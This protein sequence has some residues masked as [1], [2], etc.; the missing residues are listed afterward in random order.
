MR[1]DSALPSDSDH[2]GNIYFSLLKS[3]WDGALSLVFPASCVVCG[4]RVDS[5][6]F[7]PPCLSLLPCPVNPCER[8]GCPEIGT[9]SCPNCGDKDYVF[10]RL[11]VPWVFEDPVQ[12]LLHGLKYEGRT[13]VAPIIAA[14]MARRVR[15][16]GV[17]TPETV[18]VPV[19][20][21]PSR[22][23]E[24][25]YNQSYLLASAMARELGLLTR[26]VLRRT[27]ATAT[28]TALGQDE[29]VTNVAGAFEVKRPDAIRDR[30]VLL[31][32]DVCTTGSTLNAC[33]G[34]L[35]LA[36]AARVVAVA[37]AS[38]YRVE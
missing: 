5:S 25:G 22:L 26:D 33:T 13:F 20:L 1:H 32:D 37:A 21:H 28:Q 19:P 14:A 35:L 10:D 12:H 16:T 36:G 24:R 7:C 11:I 15:D 8:C 38:P 9:D 31:I 27:R 30:C 18:V 2:V 4:E 29:R 23:R 34:A 6:G 17:R 3:L